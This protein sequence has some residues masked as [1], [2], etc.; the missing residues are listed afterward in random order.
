MYSGGHSQ[1]NFLKD[2][3]LLSVTRKIM[4]QTLAHQCS[5]NCNFIDLDYAFSL[6]GCFKLYS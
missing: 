6:N 1:T 5:L 4:E 2:L 3:Y